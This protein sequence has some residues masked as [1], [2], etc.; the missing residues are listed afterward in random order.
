MQDGLFKCKY[1]FFSEDGMEYII[2]GRIHPAVDNIISN[3]EY[4]ITVSQTGTGYSACNS[5]LNRITRF[6][7]DM[8]EDG[9]GNFCI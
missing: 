5:N 2:T 3:G 1:G 9:M 7:Q 4:G 6:N 8:V